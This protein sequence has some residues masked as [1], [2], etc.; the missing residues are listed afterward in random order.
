MTPHECACLMLDMKN[1]MGEVKAR[2]ES[3]AGA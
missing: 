1:A 2:G 3:K